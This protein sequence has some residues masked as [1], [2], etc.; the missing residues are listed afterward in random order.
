[1]PQRHCAVKELRKSKQHR[2]HNL[3]IK[4]DLKNTVK[5]YVA[6]TKTDAKKAAELLATA[7]KKIDKAAK[8]NILHKKTASRRKSSLAKLLASQKA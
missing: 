6:L 8:R 3:D 5:E 4:S 7:Y 1:M 2:L